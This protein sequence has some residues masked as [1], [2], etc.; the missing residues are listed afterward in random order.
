MPA[1]TFPPKSPGRK[2][3]AT[4]LVSDR[5]SLSV[6][7][8]SS[9]KLGNDANQVPEFDS[10]EH[11]QYQKFK[12]NR[13]FVGVDVFMKHVLHVPEGWRKLWGRAIEKIKH[14]KAFSMAYLNYSYQCNVQD[15]GEEL[16]E[17][18]MDMTNAILGC[19]NSPL[20]DCVGPRT[21]QRY[22]GFFPHLYF[23]LSGS[24]LVDGSCMPRLKVNGKPA[25][26]SSDVVSQLIRNR[27]RS[28]ERSCTPLHAEEG[29]SFGC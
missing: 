18:L 15:A 28:T 22:V 21:D 5:T 23:K 25:K 2:R 6:G 19:S 16:C 9:L 24:T 29:N 1:T 11:A 10:A 13:V 17:P 3:D 27:A 7:T 12:R 4:R 20:E 8:S 26:A 14:D